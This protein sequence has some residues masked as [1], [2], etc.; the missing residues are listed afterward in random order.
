MSRSERD[1][2]GEQFG[3]AAAVRGRVHVQDAGTA[4][5]LRQLHGC[6]RG[7]R[8]RRRPRSRRGACRAGEHV[9][10]RAGSF[11]RRGQSATPGF[12]RS[13]YCT[14]SAPIACPDK[15]RGTLRAAD[16]AAAIAAGLGRGGLRRRRRTAACRR[17]RR[18]ARHAARRAGWV[19]SYGAGD[20]DH[21]AIRSTRSGVCCRAASP[22]SRWRA[23][24]GSRSSAPSNDPLRATTRGTGELIAVARR[25]GF[26]QCHRRG[27]RERDD[28]RR[29]RRRGR[30]RMVACKE[31]T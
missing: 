18:H 10:A 31:S 29:P 17:W 14:W 15:F 9:R 16:A 19:P 3:D 2:G 7:C 25:E 5:G 21:S 11:S 28:R 12:E 20:R 4:E 30:A 6:A 23:R 27:R 8:A 26:T 24:A 22:S 13:I 1:V